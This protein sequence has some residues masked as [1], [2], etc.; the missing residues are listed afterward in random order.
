MV[1][2]D[3]GSADLL[4]SWHELAGFSVSIALLL[5]DIGW[6]MEWP[7]I[8]LVGTPGRTKNVDV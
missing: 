4:E 5:F 6:L 1:D 8:F 3:S 7:V 2:G